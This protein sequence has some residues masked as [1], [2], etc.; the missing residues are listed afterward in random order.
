L[1]NIEELKLRQENCCKFKGSLGYK[2]ET[3]LISK[4]KNQ[5]KT[6]GFYV[7][8]VKSDL[9]KWLQITKHKGIKFH[10]SF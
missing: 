1:V 10:F 6:E 3:L 5:T 8:F 4:E 2:T 9:T 7:C